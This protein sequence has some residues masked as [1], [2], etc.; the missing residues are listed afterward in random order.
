MF[1]VKIPGING[2][3]KT[4]GC[5]KAGNFIIKSLRDIFSNE[6]GAQINVDLLEIE[7]IHLDNKNLKLTNKLIYKNSFEIYET[8]PK[9]VFLGGDHSISY[10]TTRAFLDYC[11]NSGKKPCLIVFDVNPNCM[12]FT[13]EANNFGWLRN[14]IEEGFPPE[15]V[16]LVGIRNFY[17][18]ELAF[19]KEKK[20]K[21]LSLNSILLDI[22]GS[23]DLI[24]EFSNGKEL[25][26]SIDIGVID[27]VFAPAV[28]YE[29]RIGG[30]TSREFIYLIQR[31][32]KIINLRAMDIVEINPDKD[33]RGRTVKLGAKILSEI[34]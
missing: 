11:D 8:K 15:N 2:V 32:N 33:I 31:I 26:V 17:E 34:I 23:C 9:V 6:S 19:V 18:S 13:G 14:L 29:N 21:I 5:E 20:I 3:E 25:Y 4:N 1:V 10:S 30:L 16:L 24:M 28:S 22:E 12:K 7:E 27:P